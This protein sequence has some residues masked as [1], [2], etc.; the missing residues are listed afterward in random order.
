VHKPAL[1]ATS[2][3]PGKMFPQRPRER[4]QMEMPR[5]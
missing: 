3:L 4:L 5:Y 2:Q 1:E